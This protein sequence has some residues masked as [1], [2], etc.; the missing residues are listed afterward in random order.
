MLS[1]EQVQNKPQV[2]HRLTGLNVSEFE[3]LVV[4]FEQA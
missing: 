1:C 4:S 3:Q 2:V